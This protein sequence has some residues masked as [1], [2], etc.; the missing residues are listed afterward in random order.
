MAK[1][2]LIA[3]HPHPEQSLANATI[4]EEI[5]KS[6]LDITIEDLAAK[7]WNFDIPAEQA[8][9]KA[10][11]VLVFQF[12]F[13][14]YS[15]PALLKKWVEEVLAHGFAYGSQGTALQGKDFIISFTAG[16]PFDT[17]KA[18]STQNRP[19][20]EYLYNFQQLAEFTG[21]KPHDPIVTYGCM[22]VP[23]V[24]TE[25]DKKRIISDCKKSAAKLLEELKKC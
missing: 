13:Y 22:Y 16:A 17:Y 20:A 6:D 4:L 7:G 12:P 11:D 25:E 8:A 23:G 2:L 19:V 21:M 18:G 9:V 10:A 3:G 1:I 24:S 15:Y 5:K 14:W